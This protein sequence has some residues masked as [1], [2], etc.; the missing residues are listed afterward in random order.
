MSQEAVNALAAVPQS[1]ESKVVAIRF[2]RG[3]RRPG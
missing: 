3:S 2:R 1:K